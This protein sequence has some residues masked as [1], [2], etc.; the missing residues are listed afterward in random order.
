MARGLH[1]LQRELH[2]GLESTVAE[3]L[4]SLFRKRYNKQITG[5]VKT[6]TEEALLHTPEV[7]DLLLSRFRRLTAA[8]ELGFAD[9]KPE[10]GR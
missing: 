3:R 10:V 5:Y 1:D 8:V 7:R 2:E 9:C 4:D 6:L